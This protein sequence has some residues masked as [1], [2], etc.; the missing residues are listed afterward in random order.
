MRLSINWTVSRRTIMPSYFEIASR[1][2]VGQ[3]RLVQYPQIDFRHDHSSPQAGFV[4][5]P[6]EIQTAPLPNLGW[7]PNLKS[8]RYAPASTLAFNVFRIH[9]DRDRFWALAAIS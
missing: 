9:S 2:L 4:C 3:D 6:V 1:A 5:Y 7:C 8:M